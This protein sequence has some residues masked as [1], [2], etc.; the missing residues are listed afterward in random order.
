MERPMAKA[1]ID[2]QLEADPAT[3]IR[4][5]KEGSFMHICAVNDRI[6]ERLPD[7]FNQDVADMVC[8]HLTAAKVPN[9][10]RDTSPTSPQKLAVACAV[11]CIGAVHYFAENAATRPFVMPHWPGIFKWFSFFDD[12]NNLGT[13]G[14]VPLKPSLMTLYLSPFLHHEREKILSETP[15]VTALTT[16]LWMKEAI[17]PSLPVPNGPACMSFLLDKADDTLL[18]EVIRSAGGKVEV[19][20]EHALGHIR[21]E[22]QMPAFNVT[23]IDVFLGLLGCLSQGQ[24]GLLRRAI[25]R[26]G[27]VPVVTKAFVRLAKRYTVDDIS[28]RAAIGVCANSLR[29]FTQEIDAIK[30]VR[31]M[32]LGGLLQAYIDLDPMLRHSNAIQIRA[33]TL[34][35]NDVLPRYLVYGTVVHAVGTTWD[36]LDTPQNCAVIMWSRFKD[37]WNFVL[38]RLAIGR[39][40]QEGIDGGK[41]TLRCN[42]CDRCLPKDS[43]KRCARCHFASY[44]S[45]DCQTAD[46]TN[47]HKTYCKLTVQAAEENPLYQVL[48]KHD[49]KFRGELTVYEARNN[50]AQFRALAGRLYPTTPLHELGVRII[51]HEVPPKFEVF[52]LKDYRPNR[53]NGGPATVALN[54]SILQEARRDPKNTTIIES[55]ASLGLGHDEIV[56]IENP[57]LWDWRQ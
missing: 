47:Y 6:A 42:N 57:A 39:V 27:A 40:V 45:R 37:E 29:K 48:S 55:V 9:P 16:S 19:I 20:A 21:T 32:V 38:Y 3:V 51:Y 10:R 2:R 26:K 49:K 17:D 1:N 4:L 30:C 50:V 36:K 7:L 34:L 54:R 46:W 43:M 31:A 33:L 35:F 23:F 11:S 8:S 15:G 13:A 24:K 52:L 44:C 56:A 5:A 41:A 28:V 14:Y 53:G 22:L 18:D 12:V 25:I